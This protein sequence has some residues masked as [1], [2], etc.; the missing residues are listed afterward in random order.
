MHEEKKIQ[1]SAQPYSH[2][3]VKKPISGKIPAHVEAVK[4]CIE[5]SGLTLLIASGLN[6]LI[7]LTTG[8]LTTV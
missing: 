3:A 8:L 7:Y 2:V 1:R 4:I 5:I 6:I